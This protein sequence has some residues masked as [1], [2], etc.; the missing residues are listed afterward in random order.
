MN[1]RFENKCCW[2]TRNPPELS[3]LCTDPYPLT[4]SYKNVTNRIQKEINVFCK[5]KLGKLAMHMVIERGML[6]EDMI[7][8]VTY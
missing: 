1:L 7:Q 2:K 4:N 3:T 6:E 8:H 5:M